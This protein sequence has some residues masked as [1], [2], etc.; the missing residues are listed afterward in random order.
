MASQWGRDSS[1]QSGSKRGGGVAGAVAVVLALTLGAAGGYA[2]AY[3]TQPDKSV[4]LDD[5]RAKAAE[6]DRGLLAAQ[7]DLAD[8]RAS[9]ASSA[10]QVDQLK[11]DIVR[12]AADLDT[13]AEKLAASSAPG[14]AREDKTN[15]VVQA[16]SAERDRL[17]AENQSL[18]SELAALEAER[19]ALGKSANAERARLE[20]ELARLQDEI[21]P[22]LKA[23]R[24]RLQQKVTMMLTDQATLKTRIKQASDAQASDAGVIAD[25][26]RRLADTEGELKATLTAL[27]ALERAAS[28]STEDKDPAAAA[29][30]GA[31]EAEAQA[32]K[33]AQSEQETGPAAIPRDPD[34]V[35]AALRS[36][37]G[38]ETLS[39]QDRRSLADLLVSGECVTTALET[40]FER[41]PI[42]TLRNLIRDL[43]SGC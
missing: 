27:A 36:A 32:G 11:A 16:I 21:L 8:A 33:E 2:A 25:L 30:G 20:A 43:N 12:M 42:L 6:L 5:A 23:D 22:Q 39:E 7:Q 3:F 1:F 40:I 38:L 41:V 18:G 35:A 9:Q 24:D 29:D 13:M 34:S 4:A 14:T 31:G 28:R 37:P 17:A 10:A 26:E 15:A 19:D